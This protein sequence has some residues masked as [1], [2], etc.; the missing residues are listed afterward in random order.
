MIRGMGGNILAPI[1]WRQKLQRSVGHFYV[2]FRYMTPSKRVRHIYNNFRGTVLRKGNLLKMRN[3]GR[4]LS[5]FRYCLAVSRLLKNAYNQVVFPLRGRFRYS[6][7]GQIL[8]KIWAASSISS[9][10]A[11]EGSFFIYLLRFREKSP[12]SS[13]GFAPDCTR[14]R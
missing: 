1:P 14:R 6:Y 5:D 8:G 3:F 12:P 4:S 10:W 7:D 13:C 9:R 2:G 11:A